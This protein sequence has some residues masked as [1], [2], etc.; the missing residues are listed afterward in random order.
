MCV[1]DVCATLN[2]LSTLFLVSTHT[3]LRKTVCAGL[4]SYIKH[5]R[6]MYAHKGV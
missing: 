6:K 5:P 4:K 1:T 2:P 3:F